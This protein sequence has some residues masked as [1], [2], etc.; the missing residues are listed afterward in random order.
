M[1]KLNKNNNLDYAARKVENGIS[2][3]YKEIILANRGSKNAR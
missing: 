3:L 2:N 1:S